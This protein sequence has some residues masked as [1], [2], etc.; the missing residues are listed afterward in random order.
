MEWRTGLCHRDNMENKGWDP[1][2]GAASCSAEHQALALGATSVCSHVWK[3]QH[4]DMG[5]TKPQ[6]SH[7]LPLRC[8]VFENT[9]FSLIFLPPC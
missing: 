4:M 2:P 6:R 1:I 7:Q 9:S 3:V 8:L 5:G